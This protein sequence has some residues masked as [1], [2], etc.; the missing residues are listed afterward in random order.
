M[1]TQNEFAGEEAE[2]DELEGEACTIDE[3]VDM[4]EDAV[5]IEGSA[6]AAEAA[7][8]SERVQANIA[9]QIPSWRGVR[10]CNSAERAHAAARPVAQA[11]VNATIAANPGRPVLASA[12]YGQW[13]YRNETT[14]SG[15]RKCKGQWT[16]CIVYVDFGD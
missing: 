10:S 3:D 12:Y 1:T 2:Y 4:S 8:V 14:G 15:R 16:E 11:W 13:R 5:V 6:A 9:G 7:S